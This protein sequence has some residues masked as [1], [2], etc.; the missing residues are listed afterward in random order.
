MT[1]DDVWMVIG[2]VIMSC[3]GAGVI[4]VGCSSFLANMIEKRLE[5]KY[6]QILDKEL[7]SYK[8]DLVKELEDHK[9]SLEHRRY[10]TK[11]QFDKE[12]EIYGE[13]SKVFNSAKSE[14]S[15]LSRK[16]L[17]DEFENESEL[18]SY[19]SFVYEKSL[20][21]VNEMMD[22]LHEY[23]PFI[24]EEIYMQ[25]IYMHDLITTQ[26][27]EI[28]AKHD[29]F[30]KGQGRIEDLWNDELEKRFIEIAR[31]MERLNKRLR[32]YL[33]SLSVCE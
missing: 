18:S 2:A 13:L 29:A 22:K 30:E 28:Q 24:P 14:L 10:I 19:I 17:I 12:F 31:G 15:A 4:I 11:T 16:E 6:K 1:W 21:C 33:E 23:A 9:S 20:S 25:Y 3:G 27:L 7:E 5:A 26:F 8:H 32:A